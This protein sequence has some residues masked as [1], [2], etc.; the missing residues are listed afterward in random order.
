MAKPKVIFGD[1]ELTATPSRSWANNPAQWMAGRAAIDE[2]DALAH[3]LEQE[4][5]AGRLRLLVG[6]ELREKF[7]RQRYLFNQAIW[8]GTLDDVRREAGRMVKAWHAVEAAASAQGDRLAPVVWEVAGE[9]SGKVFAIVRDG[10]DARA[11]QADGRQ[12]AVYTLD[13]IARLLEGFPA[14]AVAKAE[15]PGAAVVAV[16]APSDPLDGLADS[17]APVGTLSDEIPF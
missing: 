8:H 17:A 7:D 11:V 1:A 3:R 4:W 12:V 15:F 16:R 14:I 9:K 2:A 10:A 5:G 13:E 6:V